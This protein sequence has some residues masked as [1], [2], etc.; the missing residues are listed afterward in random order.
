MSNKVKIDSD[1]IRK[2][3]EDKGISLREFCR[4][5]NLCSPSTF[6]TWLKEGEVVEE[7]VPALNEALYSL[8]IFSYGSAVRNANAT[9]SDAFN[10]LTTAVRKC[11]G[12]EDDEM[13][14]EVMDKIYPKKFSKKCS[15]IYKHNADVMPMMIAEKTADFYHAV[16]R[17]EYWHAS[18][19]KD[20]EELA[21]CEE[22]LID[23]MADILIS[24]EC[25]RQMYGIRIDEVR[26]AIKKKQ[27]KA[28]Y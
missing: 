15:D 19:E 25:A 5:T 20:Y 3:L 1:G 24:I 11:L 23:K 8:G 7:R 28:H 17:T 21:A 13:E 4:K 14:E 9:L 27:K 22:N 10:D 16:C 12:L 2:G 6:C 26:K 18:E